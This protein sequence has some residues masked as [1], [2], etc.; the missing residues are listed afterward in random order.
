MKNPFLIGVQIYLRSIEESDITEAYQSWFN[1]PD[2][3][4][5]NDHHRFPLYREQM[6]AYYET[7]IK[8]RSNLILAIIDIASDRHIGNVALESID[9][10]NRSAEFAII[11]GDKEAWGKGIGEEAGRLLIR[12]GFNELNLHRIACGTSRENVGM[13]KL[14]TKL[15]FQEEGTQREAMFKHGVYQDLIQYGLLSYEFHSTNDRPLS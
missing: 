9:L 8:S 1:N 14:A 7:V 12:H 6:R 4:R 3:C 2:V 15:G 10:V 13:Q 11:V 5:F